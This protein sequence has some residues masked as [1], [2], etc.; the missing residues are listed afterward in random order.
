MQKRVRIFAGPNGSGKSSIIN[1]VLGLE[2][3]SGKK[4]DVGVY[5]NADDIAQELQN[6]IVRFHKY[7]IKVDRIEFD[8]IVSSSGL[9]SEKFPIKRFESCIDISRNTLS[10]NHKIAQS[11]NDWAYERIAQIT[12][13]YLRNKLLLNGSKFT[14]E[15]VFSHPDKVAFMKRAQEQGYKVYLYFVSTEHP[16]INVFRVKDVR[17]KQG[18]HDVAK[19]KIISRYFNSMEQLYKACQYCYRVYFFDN[20]NDGLDEV[21]FANFHAPSG[22]KKWSRIDPK[23]A[24]KWFI[25]YYSEKVGR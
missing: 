16:L 14:F 22:E 6:K 4:L 11:K 12:A 1:H 13:N 24:P 7:G 2:V 18:G 21:L 15:T 3:S 19:E 9:L 23:Q 17:V 25:K 8:H 5:V 10:I 20:S